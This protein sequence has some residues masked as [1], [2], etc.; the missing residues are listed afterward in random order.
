MSRRLRVGVAV[1]LLRLPPSGGHGKVWNRTLRELRKK[2]RLVR[3][4]AD[5]RPVRRAIPGRFEVVL[6]SGHEE[7]FSAPGPLVI[8]VHEAGWFD[9][10]SRDTLDRTFLQRI[11]AHTE[12]NVHRAAR[13][14]TPSE[15]AR[16]DVI[17]G[18]GLDPG[19]VHVVHHG[20]DPG[21]RP[22]ADVGSSFIARARGAENKPYVLY[23]ATLHPRKNV[24]ALRA[25]IAALAQEGFPHR[26]VI[27]GHPAPDR[28]DDS[29]LERAAAAELPGAPGR[30]AFLGQPSDRELAGL[31]AGADAF[32]LPSL[33]E[34]FGLTVLEAMACGTAVVVSDRGALPEV[35]GEAGVVVEPTP[36]AIAEGLRRVL[37]DPD[38]RIRLEARAVER[39]CQFSW[40]RTAAGW[41]RVL[42][43][44]VD[45]ETYTAAR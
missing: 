28:A 25:A 11:A 43:S 18:Y 15:S 29:E 8:Q 13:V 40:R 27:A 39:A 9:H 1:Q 24:A 42:Q 12:H 34:G 38:Q 45:A 4:G 16:R 30:V 33:Y 17:S 10:R 26:L 2:A 3:L 14:I 36:S 20:V 31:M 22:G 41:L 37:A 44:A 32:C 23:A 21:F 7:L 6:A 19:R 5:G 35:V